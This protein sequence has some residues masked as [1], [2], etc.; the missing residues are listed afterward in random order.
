MGYLSMAMDLGNLARLFVANALLSSPATAPSVI[1]P[2][3][4]IPFTGDWEEEQPLTMAGGPRGDASSSY[5]KLPLT[6][7]VPFGDEAHLRVVFKRM[8][9]VMLVLRLTAL[10][11]AITSGSIFFY[12]TKSPTIALIVQLTRYVLSI[13]RGVL[14]VHAL[15]A[16][17]DTAQRSLCSSPSSWFWD[18]SFGLYKRVHSARLGSPRS[19]SLP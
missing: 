8:K 16:V 14:K 2:P 7:H 10:F 19:T 9:I 6:E 18:W 12:G 5:S 15:H 17:L 1:P 11:P 3:P 4:I 13:L